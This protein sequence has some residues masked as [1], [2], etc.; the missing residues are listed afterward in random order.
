M[1]RS[2][3]WLTL[4]TIFIA[5]ALLYPGITQPVLT[6]SG[7][8]EKSQLAELGIDMLAGENTS[9]RGHHMLSML[10]SLLGLDQIEG[11]LQAYHSTRSIWG[12]ANDLARSG[13]LLVA[14]L[15]VVFSIVIPVFKLLFMAFALAPVSARVS[16]FLL[17]INGRLSKW[18]MS[19]V[20]VMG[21]LLAYLAGSA[22]GEM[23]DLLIMDA[24]LEAGFYYFLGYCLFSIAAGGLLGPDQQNR[25]GPRTPVTPGHRQ[26]GSP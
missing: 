1:T 2:R 15:I 24:H 3:K 16:R 14:V 22:S 13:S 7:S 19:D 9:R 17:T 8:I 23:G 5:I 21:L 18:S 6:L 25:S 10:S 26:A 11:R 12:T 4:A 20:F